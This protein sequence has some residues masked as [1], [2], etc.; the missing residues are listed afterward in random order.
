MYICSEE[1]E[2]TP[3]LTMEHVYRRADGTVYAMDCGSNYGGHLDGLSITLQESGTFSDSTGGRRQ[4]TVRVKL[5]VKERAR[6]E[7]VRLF[8]MRGTEV[9]GEIMLG[10]DSEVWLLPDTE[11]VLMEE[12]LSDGSVRRTAFNRPL[13]STQIELFTVC[14]N[15]V[16]IPQRI[17]LRKAGEE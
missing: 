7:Q 5:N 13:D 9:V 4:H 12:R 15:G 11:W 3:Y 14:E 6:V 17:T 16:F 8:D 2:S 1:F 10:S